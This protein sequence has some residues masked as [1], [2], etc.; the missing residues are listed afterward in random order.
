M[1]ARPLAQEGRK[2]YALGSPRSWQDD[3][4]LSTAHAI[5]GGGSILGRQASMPRRVLYVD[6][7]MPIDDLKDRCALLLPTVGSDRAAARE[8]LTILARHNQQP[9][10][11]FPN[12]AEHEERVSTGKSSEHKVQAMTLGLISDPEWTK[13]LKAVRAER[14][15]VEVGEVSPPEVQRAEVPTRPLVPKTVSPLIYLPGN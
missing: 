1:A 5:A 15:G 12:I 2:R 10:A 7:E 9:E 8:N 4:P 11:A 13:L 14:D 6:G 3:A